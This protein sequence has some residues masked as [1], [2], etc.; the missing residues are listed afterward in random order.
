MSKVQ[1]RKTEWEDEYTLLC[2]RCGYIIEDLDHSLPCPECGKPINESLPER[3]V[4]TPWQQKPGLKSLLQTWWVTI[5]HPKETLDIMQFDT[6]SGIGQSFL[7]QCTIVIIGLVIGALTQLLFGAPRHDDGMIYISAGTF[8]V[9]IVVIQILTLIEALGLIFIARRRKI[10]INEEI[11]RAIVNHGSI[12]W[13]ISLASLVLIWLQHIFT[14]TLDLIPEDGVYD[15]LSMFFGFL[16]MALAAM[17]LAG[18][19]FFE[20]FAYLGLRRCKYANRSRPTQT[21][22]P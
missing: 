1:A 9:L 7:P 17:T 11:A 20:T 22:Q 2:E 15:P 18:F 4:G 16:I 13:C 8:V 21:P 5:R 6:I 3:R 12:G 19:L 10:R 14:S